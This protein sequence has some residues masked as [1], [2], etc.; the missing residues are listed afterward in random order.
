MLTLSACEDSLL[1]GSRGSVPM[2]SVVSAR[3][4]EKQPIAY[5]SADGNWVDYPEGLSV[6]G[7]ED[8][9]KVRNEVGGY[10]V[11]IPSTSSVSSFHEIVAT[12]TKFGQ[13]VEVHSLF[14]RLNSAYWLIQYYDLATEVVEQHS[15]D[16]LLDEARDAALASA[17]S[18]R[19]NSEV[20]VRLGDALGRHFVAPSALRGAGDDGTYQ[21]RIY[22]DD[23]RI[24][25]VA[26]YTQNE[27]YCEC[28]EQVDNF[29]ESFQI[30]N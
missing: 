23:Q 27:D 18:S 17:S 19:M 6:A 8:V 5:L 21:A 16:A 4:I 25:R 24:Y 7:T 22:I 1:A 12:E 29:L 14:I 30:I 26:S 13:E 20:D 3:D 15:V 11:L 9:L 28:I 10:E 2:L